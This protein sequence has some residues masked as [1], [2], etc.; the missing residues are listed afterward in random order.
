MGPTYRF[1]QL[2]KNQI[3]HIYRLHTYVANKWTLPQDGLGLAA[4]IIRH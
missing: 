4:L 2:I 1:V 3:Y